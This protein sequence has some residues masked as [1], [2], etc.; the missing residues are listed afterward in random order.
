MELYFDSN[1]EI[2][3]VYSYAIVSTCC[4]YDVL[5]RSILTEI[6]PM[7]IWCLDIYFVGL[8]KYFASSYQMPIAL[9]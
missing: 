9:C 1:L 2:V 6:A 4:S 5:C 3:Y 8:T 7:T